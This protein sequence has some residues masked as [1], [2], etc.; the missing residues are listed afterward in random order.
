MK[1][2]VF[3]IKTWMLFVL[4]ACSQLVL[5]SCETA[6]NPV[7]QP[8]SNPQLVLTGDA[9]VEWTKEHL[10]S[11]V[12]VYL[13]GCG[14][15]VDPDD[16]RALLSC[17]GYTGLNVIDYMAASD[18][19]DSVAYIRLMER[20]IDADNKTILFTMGMSGCGKTT[21]L[22]NNPDL[23]RQALAA[24]VVYDAAFFTTADFDK[25]IKKSNERGLKPTLVYVYNDAETGFSSCVS[26]L[27][28]TNRVVPYPTYV[29][30]F[31]CYKGRIEYLEEHYPDMTIHCID[32][33]HNNGGFE[34]SKEEARKWD[35][36]MDADMQNKLYK[37]MWQFILSGDMTDEQIIAVQKPERM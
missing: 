13:G 35:Y 3:G 12:G 17:I 25:V 6:D 16:T 20:A 4:M 21:S 36:T 28:A 22:R 14:N 26:R 34:V 29:M 23:Y 10:D 33:N 2:T 8:Q 37:I 30:F 9:A 11:L 19:I 18:L 32:N 1:K 24:G 5:I 7:A 15:K 31:P 27:I